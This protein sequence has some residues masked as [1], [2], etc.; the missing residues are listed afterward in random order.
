MNPEDLRDTSTRDLPF[1]KKSVENPLGAG[2]ERPIRLVRPLLDVPVHPRIY[3]LQAQKPLH[4]L[5]LVKRN[6]K[7]KLAKIGQ[8]LFDQDTLTRGMAYLVAN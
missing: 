2:R 5:D 6:F 4:G 1:D 7:D 8:L 3:F